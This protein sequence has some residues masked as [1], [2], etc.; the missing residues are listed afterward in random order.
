M[1]ALPSGASV[2]AAIVGELKL[3]CDPAVLQFSGSQ[4]LFPSSPLNRIE[5]RWIL[6]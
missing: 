5:L 2:S 4:I 6:T 3:S 1:H